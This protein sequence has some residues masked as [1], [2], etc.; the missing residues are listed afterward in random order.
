MKRPVSKTVESRLGHLFT[1]ICGVGS[2][3]LVFSGCAEE[4]KVV[5]QPP[6]PAYVKPAPVQTDT[7]TVENAEERA[8]DIRKVCNRKATTSPD[9]GRCW[10]AESERIGGKK[11]EAQFR[12]MLYVQPDGTVSDLNILNPQDERKDLEKCV[13]EA[14]KSWPFPT[15]QTVSPVQCNFFMR[16]IM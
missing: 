7:P 8:E 15:G 2:V 5:R 4:A 10:Q 14:V 3:M 16:A 1:S 9:L 13:M 11:F 6:A 12:L